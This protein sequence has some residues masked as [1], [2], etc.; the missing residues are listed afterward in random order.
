[1]PACF[2]RTRAKSSRSRRIS[3][4]T[5]ILLIPRYRQRAEC[6]WSGVD[7]TTVCR[8]FEFGYPQSKVQLGASELA[9]LHQPDLVIRRAS[10]LILHRL[11]TGRVAD[12]EAVNAMLDDLAVGGDVA[13]L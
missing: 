5:P 8:P 3:S 12:G 2:L 13:R 9:L 1:M 4:M 6:H 7:V 10:N 11:S